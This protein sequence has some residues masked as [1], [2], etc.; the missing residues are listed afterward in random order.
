MAPRKKKVEEREVDGTVVL[1]TAL[2]LILLSFFIMMNTMA[3][4]DDRKVRLAIGSLLGEFGRVTGGVMGGIR[5]SEEGIDI[6][7]NPNVDP[8]ASRSTTEVFDILEQTRIEHEVDGDVKVEFRGQDLVLSIDG[9][10]I[11][12]DDPEQL[13]E[14]V[15]VLLDKIGE[16]LLKTNREIRF[17]GHATKEPLELDQPISKTE[18]SESL[19]WAQNVANYYRRQLPEEQLV[20]AGYGATRPL[21]SH[22]SSLSYKNQRVEIVVVDGAEDPALRF[23]PR[24]VKMGRWTFERIDERGKTWFKKTK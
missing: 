5:S 12:G 19:Q 13:P 14:A 10:M 21:T 18:W 24:T 2:M 6:G 4:F 16:L 8:Q 11:I 1:F 9:A 3:V 15:Q 22:A 7:S 23:T 17:E 20:V